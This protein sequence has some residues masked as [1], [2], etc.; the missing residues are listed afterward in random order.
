MSYKAVGFDYGGV[1]AGK[2]FWV[3]LE[4]IGAAVGVSADEA[5]RWHFANNAKANIR[6]MGWLEYWGG[7]LSEHGK[8]DK[9]EALAPVLDAWNADQGVDLR[10]VGLMER[11]KSA[12]YRIGV[13]SNARSQLR[14]EIVAQGLDKVAD[15][16]CISQEEGLMKP[17]PRLFGIFIGRLGVRPEELVYTDDSGRSLET[18]NEV[19]Y[20]PILFQSYEKL[21]EELGRLGMVVE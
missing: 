9:L 16:V 20:T 3:L 13:L 1:I 7:I 2:P 19:G 12:G 5:A 4:R 6:G 21:T 10:M 11:L 14:E 15:V 18:A 8:S 17:D